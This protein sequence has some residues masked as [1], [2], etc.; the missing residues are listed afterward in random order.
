MKRNIKLIIMS[1][2]LLSILTGC[3]KEEAP[4]LDAV[5]VKEDEEAAYSV[6]TPAYDSVIHNA[7]LTAKYE[8]TQ[9]ENLSFPMSNRLITDVYVKTDDFVEKGQ[10]IA[11]VEM[12]DIE[13]RIDEE[14]FN[15]SHLELELKQIHENL[16]FDLESARIRYEAYSGKTDEDQKAY[17]K[18]IQNIN[19]RYAKQIRDMEDRIS[20]RRQKVG[21]INK[22]LE[23]G[24][25]YSDISGQVIY[26]DGKQKGN[27][28]VEN[29]LIAK[30][31]DMSSSFFMIDGTE[32]SDYFK[33]N[34]PITFS[35]KDSGKSYE[36]IGYPKQK[37]SWEELG[38]IYILPETDRNI[39]SGATATIY[40]ELGR[41]D[42]VLCIP[43]DAIHTS[44]SGPFVYLDVDGM[45][46]MRYIKLGLEGDEKT[47]ILEGLSENDIIAIKK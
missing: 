9:T 11:E 13:D 24:R 38:K 28:S 12:G 44:D 1:A 6:C 41:K 36:G 42:N 47:E 22:E 21:Q 19:D 26:L 10:L 29:Q 14:E 33:E 40:V 37:D 35:Y 7:K 18:E 20:I 45:L 30:V 39:N 5:I 34:E 46:E 43:N 25:I 17:K 23:E 16:D 8:A 32:F 27:Y 4:D 3:N 15:L 2:A 31:S